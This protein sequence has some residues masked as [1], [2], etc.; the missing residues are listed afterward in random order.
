MAK[1]IKIGS[2]Y[3]DMT[4]FPQNQTTNIIVEMY[5]YS[6]YEILF[7]RDISDMVVDYSYDCTS[8]DNIHQTASLT[9]HVETDD[10]MWFMKRENKM[11]EWVDEA[12]GTLRSVSWSKY[13]YHLV[14]TY[15]NDDDPNRE[16]F[17]IDL[18][19][20][21]PT[22]DD[23]SYSPTDGT[24]NISLSGLSALL[25]KE[26]GGSVVTY[27]ET[28][29]VP[30]LDTEHTSENTANNNTNNNSSNNENTSE[31]DNSSTNTTTNQVYKWVKMTLPVTLSIAEGLSIDG[32]LIYNMAMGAAAQDVTFMN[33]TAPIPLKWG[34]VGDGQKL[35]QLPYDLD[36]DNDIGRA[37]ELQQLMDMAFEGATFWVDEDRVLNMSSKP[38]KRDGIELYWREYGNLFLSDG[39]SYN[40][41]GYYNITEVYGKDNNYYAICDWSDLDGG[42]THFAR[43]QVISDDTLQTNEECYARARWETYKARYGHQTWTVTIADRYISKFNKP[44]KIVGKRV[45]YTTVDGD[46]NLFFLNK[47]SYSGNK[48]T[49]ELSLFRPLYE[50]DMKQYAV[51]LH[52]P[53]IYA[54]EIID[55]K[56]IRLY[57]TGEDIENAVVKIYATDPYGV[58]GASAGFRTESCLVAD[59]GV[60]KYVDIEIKGNGTYKFDA[61]LYSPNYLDSGLTSQ[62]Y[63]VTI[64]LP[65]P[66]RPD[67]NPYPHPIFDE[68]G[69]EPYLLD[70]HMRV[71]TDGNGN[72]LTI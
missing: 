10:Q 28:K 14:K 71:L 8:D 35:W 2:D 70:G 11:R 52:T 25:T 1:S 23:Y 66:V 65:V 32:D 64:D 68:G 60:D 20:F 19:Y 58:D 34:K 63:T 55:N 5:D 27:T 6:H 53:Q 44:S 13:C 12:S 36:F 37:D 17:K 18:G 51:Q 21:I 56:Y 45:E 42:I 62:W 72:A 69:H 67:T 48:W 30:V 49:M 31:N 57:V 9:L 39:S 3:F 29:L 43:K 22:S 47:L 61:A 50:T 4:E 26:K 46:T 59:N 33:Y 41:D 16:L 54:H 7:V 24:I 15:I 40:D 38:T